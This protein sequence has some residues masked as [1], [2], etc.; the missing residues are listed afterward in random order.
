MKYTALLFATLLPCMLFAQTQK[1]TV[2]QPM[3]GDQHNRPQ[4]VQDNNE[5][6]LL[7]ISSQ[8]QNEIEQEQKEEVLEVVTEIGSTTVKIATSSETVPGSLQSEIDPV[9]ERLGRVINEIN[10]QYDQDVS[11]CSLGSWLERI[12]CR[13][14]AWW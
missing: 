10:S 11:T 3:F 13:L 7:G 8:E 12:W 4:L 5:S 9:E 14:F 2:V 6:L 1:A